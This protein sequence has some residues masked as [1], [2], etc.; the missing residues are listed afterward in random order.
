MTR[1]G[2]NANVIEEP[3][4]EGRVSCCVRREHCNTGYFPVRGFGNSYTH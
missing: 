2:D 3:R 4:G 1:A